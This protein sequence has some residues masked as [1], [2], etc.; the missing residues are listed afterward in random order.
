MSSLIGLVNPCERTESALT[1]FIMSFHDPSACPEVLR[2]NYL[3]TKSACVALRNG[4]DDMPSQDFVSAVFVA[5][6]KLYDFDCECSRPW[7]SGEC[8]FDA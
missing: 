4:R 2:D 7:P 6:Q 3:K 5:P 1:G 8:V